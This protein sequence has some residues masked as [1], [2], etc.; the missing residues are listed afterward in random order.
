MFIRMTL[1][2]TEQLLTFTDTETLN[3]YINLKLEKER[4]EQM[5]ELMKDAT[6][7]SD[8]FDLDEIQEEDHDSGL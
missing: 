4:Q 5:E 3:K 6:D 7:I 2:E 1:T 8:L